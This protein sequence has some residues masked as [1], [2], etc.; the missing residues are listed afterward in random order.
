MADATSLFDT[1]AGAAGHPV[2]RAGLNNYVATSQATNG[3]RS[4]QTTEALLKAQS[5]VDEQDAQGHLEGALGDLLG[6]GNEAKAHAASIIMK[7]HFGD[8]RTA[9][10]AIKSAKQSGALDVLGDPTKLGT[11]EQTAASQV[12][13]GKLAPLTTVP[14]NYAVPAGLPAP[15]VLQSPEGAA[16]TKNYEATGNLHQEQADNPSA[17]HP[18]KAAGSGTLSGDDARL[19]AQYIHDN[20]NAAGNLRSLLSAPGGVDVIRALYGAPTSG[21]A[22][23]GGGGGGGGGGAAPGPVISQPLSNG[24]TVPAGVSLKEQADIRHGFAG[25]LESRQVTAL[26]T[27]VQHSQLFDA[28]A[29]ELDNGNSRPT[30]YIAN[31]WNRTMQGTPLP[32]DLKIAGA[33]LGREAVRATVNSGA[34]TGHERELGVDE[35]SSSPQLHGAANTLRQLA[36]GQLHSLD[37]KARR[38]GVDISSLLDPEAQQAYGYRPGGASPIS[39]ANGVAPVQGAAPG[40]PA[41]ALSITQ[42]ARGP[43]PPPD[44]LAK[45]KEGVHTHTRG[46]SV[47]TLRNGQAVQ[48]Q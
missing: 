9:F 42:A 36:G 44:F 32:T 12:T 25:G 41:P 2:N 15:T 40:E 13:T 22:P 30:N 5:A 28:I 47:W 23:A 4:A 31:L 20:P 45:L 6:P 46:G 43:A 10:E 38:G 48:L 19:I 27:M 37:L 29:N 16:K 39:G 8:A 17:F 21:A 18:G 34:G 26:N 11:P 7:S 35:N 24:I 3:L 14:D 1:L 33:F